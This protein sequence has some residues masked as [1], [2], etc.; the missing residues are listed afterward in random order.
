MLAEWAI[1]FPVFLLFVLGIAQLFLLLQGVMIVKY[2][3]Y[4]TARSLLVQDF[5]RESDGTLAEIGEK[6][7]ALACIGITGMANRS[8]YPPTSEEEI[9]HLANRYREDER[10]HAD[11]AA[12]YTAARDK[13]R[14]RIVDRERVDDH[15]RVTVEVVHDFE[16]DIPIVN[17]LLASSSGEA[18]RFGYPHRVLRALATVES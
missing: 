3:A 8:S 18:S 5:E 11:F 10:S 16:L 1:V 6:S 4:A 15:V 7:A 9:L 13:T 2:A 17:H 12:R 14:I